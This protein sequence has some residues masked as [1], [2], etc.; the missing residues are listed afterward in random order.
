MPTFEIGETVE[1]QSLDRTGEIYRKPP[2]TD[3]VKQ[4]P[5]EGENGG[6][7]VMLLHEGLEEGP[8][9]YDAVV[10]VSPEDIK[11]LD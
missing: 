11:Q 10:T 8:L 5:E 6:V 3:T 1:V 4:H 9:G 2:Y 7:Q